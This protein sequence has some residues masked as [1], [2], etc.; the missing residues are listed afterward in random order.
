[1]S[2]TKPYSIKDALHRDPALSILLRKSG[3][4]YHMSVVSIRPATPVI[5]EVA[6]TDANWTVIATGLTGVLAWKLT[7]RDGNAFDYCFDNGVA[8]TSVRSYGAIQRDT[9]LSAVYV[10]RT[11]GTDIN[12]QLEYWTA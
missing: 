7:E 8:G 9:A 2:L 12:M 5:T 11:G 4:D 1:M 10:K 6:T 3:T